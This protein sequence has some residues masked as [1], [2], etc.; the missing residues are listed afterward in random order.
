MQLKISFFHEPSDKNPYWVGLRR[1]RVSKESYNRL[2]VYKLLKDFSKKS[3][4]IVH[5]ISST[6]LKDFSKSGT[7]FA[8]F[9]ALGNTDSA[10]IE[11]AILSIGVCT[12]NTLPILINFIRT[13]KKLE[14]QKMI[15]VKFHEL[16]CLSAQ[17]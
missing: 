9:R 13:L 14:N 10:N 17:L 2:Y 3:N 4:E 1:L 5:I 6:L 12:M 16:F 15:R 8:C 11:L 7:I